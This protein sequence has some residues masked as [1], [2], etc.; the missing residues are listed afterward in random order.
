MTEVVAFAAADSAILGPLLGDDEIARLFTD[1]ACVEAM[2][3]FEVGLAN[4]QAK[5]GVIPAGAAQVIEVRARGFA[6]NL[7]EMGAS[8][9]NAAVPTIALVQ[10]LRAHLAVDEARYVHWGATSQDVIDTALVLRLRATL[11]VFETRLRRLIGTLAEAADAHR[12]TVMPARTRYQQ[13]LPTS[14]GLKLAS[15]LAPLPRQLTRLDEMRPR[16]LCVQF[17]GAAGTLAAL[18]KRGVETMSA[19]AT[20]LDLYEPDMH[21]HSQRDGFA[22]LA[23]WLSLLTGVLG[24]FGQDIAL[25]QQSEFGELRE[26]AD[27]ARGGSSTMPQKANPIGAEALVALARFNAGLLGN[28]HQAIIQ[29]NERGGPG[30]QL[31]WMT[32]PQMLASTGAAL[33]QAQLIADG[34]VVDAERM[35]A[36]LA[37]GHGLIMAEALSF[38]LAE[39]MPRP[40]AQALVKD[41]CRQALAEGRPLIE[42]MTLATDAPV[43]WDAAADPVNYLG[44][45]DAFIDRVLA[46]AQANLRV[47]DS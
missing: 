13:A 39:H 16:L 28:M 46:S 12:A 23:N 45:A 31:E 8:T 25:H 22:E 24:K 18:G 30:W 32:L 42:V 34:F 5:T 9:A 1:A 43:D 2:V 38:A 20:E 33:R 4:A 17:G 19:L 29:E 26:S 44:D 3:R 41:C 37:D 21:W 10:Q 6:A 40:Q 7:A 11:G 36:N 27:P 47:A 35:R 15:W 14:L